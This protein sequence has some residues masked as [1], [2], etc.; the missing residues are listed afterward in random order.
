[1][2]SICPTCRLALRAVRRQAR[3]YDGRLPSRALPLSRTF[4][5]GKVQPNVAA[6]LKNQNEAIDEYVD[7]RS[8][9]QPQ[10]ALSPEQREFLDG[11]V[12]FLIFD[13]VE[14]LD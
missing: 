2:S 14:S 7:T 5:E 4:H 6:A 3:V 11:A 9:S 13:I 12:R 10:R 8:P 1:M